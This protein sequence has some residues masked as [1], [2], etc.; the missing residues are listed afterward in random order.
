[1]PNMDG[2]E[3]L[4]RVRQ[5]KGYK[6]TPVIILSSREYEDNK[7]KWEELNIA[8]YLS[9]PFDVNLMVQSVE[10]IVKFI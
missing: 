7:E 6:Y 8:D 1:M 2:Y 9:K 10:K 5:L 4:K 3:F